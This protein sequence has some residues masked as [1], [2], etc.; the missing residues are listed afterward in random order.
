[1]AN[2]DN[3]FY[4][5]EN[6]QMSDAQQPGNSQVKRGR[7]DQLRLDQQ[8]DHPSRPRSAPA[9]ADAPNPPFPNYDFGYP[10]VASAD[11]FT[12][13]Y[14]QRP[15]DPRLPPPELIPAWGY[16]DQVP[17]QQFYSNPGE[18]ENEEQE[19]DYS[20]QQTLRRS[21]GG[22]RVRNAVSRPDNGAQ[23]YYPE[24]SMYFAG[25]AEA[26]HLNMQSLNLDDGNTAYERSHS[27]TQHNKRQSH[28]PQQRSVGVIGKTQAGTIPSHG[29]NSAMHPKF[30]SGAYASG[31][32][33]ATPGGYSPLNQGMPP[34]QSLYAP[35]FAAM[36]SHAPLLTPGFIAPPM[37]RSYNRPNGGTG[38]DPNGNNRMPDQHNNSERKQHGG[39]RRRNKTGD[40][41]GGRN[42]RGGDNRDK[43]GGPQP[44]RSLYS[45]GVHT[46]NGPSSSRR[47]PQQPPV[48]AGYVVN[49]GMPIWPSQRSGSPWEELHN[50]E[51]GGMLPDTGGAGPIYNPFSAPGHSPLPSQEAYLV[52][53]YPVPQEDPHA[54]EDVDYPQARYP[55]KTLAT[56]GGDRSSLLEEFRNGKNLKFELKSI[57]GHIVEFSQDQHGSRF[58]QQ[59]LET[60]TNSEKELVFQEILPKCLVLMQDVFGNYVIQKFFEYGTPQQ[61]Q[62]LGHKLH[63]NILVL[64]CQMYGCRVVQKALEAITED[65]QELVV[66]ELRGD[67]MECVKDQNGNHV[68]Q[69]CIEKVPHHLIRCIVEKFYGQVYQLA[70]HPYGCRVIQRIL[71]HC[72][73]DQTKAIT[74]ELLRFT[75]NLVQDQY[76]NYVIQHVLI[77]GTPSAKIGVIHKLRGN[78][79]VLSQH[80]FASNVVEKCIKEGND[81]ERSH[82]I[83]EILA[84]TARGFIPL[85]I[86]MKDQYANYVVQKLIDVANPM[87]REML[88]QK[89]LPH[90]AQLK[91]FT[92]GKH[93][94]ARIEKLTGQKLK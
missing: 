93:I 89:I 75:P 6:P 12:Y 45:N 80:K 22:Q 85:H 73:S 11:Y 68:I 32:P 59:K 28:N 34:V 39:N 27:P 63:G 31:Y 3:V 16:S 4:N 83:K 19:E 50:P 41:R 30:S 29:N 36:N 91:K 81:E 87:Q 21:A 1:M 82:I 78:I 15:L 14:S 2:E 20:E 67:I 13:Y 74:D 33:I 64:S 53:Q 86:M 46:N 47:M 52:Q 56:S 69:K 10:D 58:I 18:F 62:T 92:Y 8:P 25:D 76:G 17:P 60:A 77:H 7:L 94:I 35:Q 65:Q 24:D 5:R 79:L 42:S 88:V 37:N 51:S 26:L 49:D 61:I 70:R 54:V 84:P 48:G 55:S 66:K 44:D 71:E 23:M 9:A 38:G 72:P 57:I 90:L 40:R 43:R